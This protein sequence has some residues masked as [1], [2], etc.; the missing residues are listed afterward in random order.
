MYAFTSCES[1]GHVAF[2]L[3]ATLLWRI[4]SRTHSTLD[5]EREREFAALS[6]DGQVST[7]RLGGKSFTHILGLSGRGIFTNARTIQA[8]DGEERAPPQWTRRRG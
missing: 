3:T 6:C 1:G 5:G 4:I 8:P 7:F 2:Q